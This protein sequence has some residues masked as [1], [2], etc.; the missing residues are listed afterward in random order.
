MQY[1][2]RKLNL[3]MTCKT[4]YHIK[5]FLR[6]SFLFHDFSYFLAA[7]FIIIILSIGHYYFHQSSGIVTQLPQG[8]AIVNN[9]KLKLEVV[10]KG[11][12]FPTSMAFL[13]PNDIL[14]LEKNNGTVKRIVNGT[15]LPEPLLDVSVGDRYERGM[16]GIAVASKHG[17]NKPAYVFL[18]YTE[19][20][21]GKDGDDRGTNTNTGKK[22]LGNRLYRYELENNKLV[23]PKL[24]LDLPATPGSIHNGGKIKIGPDDNVYLTIGD[25][26][27]HRT[28]AENIKNGTAVDGT[29]GIL[30]VTQ[31]GQPVKQK[32]GTIGIIGNK[33][34]LN[35]Y[36][37]YGIRNSFGIDFDPLTKRLWDTEN[38]QSFGDEINLVEPGFNSGWAKVQGAWKVE[39]NDRIGDNVSKP[40]NLVDFG[41]RG[42]YRLPE[43]GTNQT[44]APTAIQFLKSNKYGKQYENDMF[45]SAFDTGNIYRF[46]LNEERTGLYLT[47]DL[48][49][50]IAN[51]PKDLEGVVFAKGFGGITDLEIGPDGFLY[52]SSLYQGAPNCDPKF[53]DREGHCISFSS[54]LDGTIFRL[55]PTYAR[56]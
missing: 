11:I 54:P 14:V 8:P 41:G 45:V 35:L 2:N 43:L 10:F 12:K 32:N 1:T 27:G 38:G 42:Q 16:L 17:E 53:P 30:R 51:T 3:N 47:G 46:D 6:T 23:N 29:G 22:T 25:V 31:D 55:V 49:D 39:K 36:Y 48:A 34:P 18:Y 44:V 21:G 24:L 50:K 40:N 56:P 9:T 7:I 26:N 13:G 37:A 15:M 33:F 19:S 5:G 52:V 28:K 20:S 4:S